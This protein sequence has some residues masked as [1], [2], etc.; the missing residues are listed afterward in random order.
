MVN[1]SPIKE[2]ETQRIIDF[3]VSNFLPPKMCLSPNPQ[4]LR[5]NKV[6]IE[7]IKL[8]QGYQCEP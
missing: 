7:E 4:Y 6:F 8:R 1:V 5:K 3:R 2:Y